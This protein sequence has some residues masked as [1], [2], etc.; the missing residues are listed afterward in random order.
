MSGKS[1]SIDVTVQV[2]GLSCEER[3]ALFDRNQRLA[4]WAAKRYGAR[5]GTYLQY[6]RMLADDLRQA[7]R[8]GLWRASLGWSPNMGSKFTSY[9]VQC[10]VNEMHRTCSREASH[11]NHVSLDNFS[12]VLP[13]PSPSPEAEVVR[14]D[15][16]NVVSIR[17]AARRVLRKVKR[18]GAEWT[19]AD[20]A[21]MLSR[22]MN[23]SQVAAVLGVSRQR[24]G[25][26]VEMLR[27]EIAKA[28]SA[29]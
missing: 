11:S 19:A 7:A 26:I 4:E 12:E 13:D 21:D 8:I 9:A 5:E 25:Q 29:G 27:Q 16:G 2:T 17:E 14:Q 18:G 24:I 28:E 15:P 6:R 10:M 22:G 23:Q 1:T 3:K 20:V